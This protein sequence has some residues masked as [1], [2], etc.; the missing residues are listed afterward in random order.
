MYTFVN[1]NFIVPHVKSD[2][3]IYSLYNILLESTI[4]NNP[5]YNKK[6][7]IYDSKK[8]TLIYS[9]GHKLHS[10]NNNVYKPI[11]YEYTNIDKMKNNLFLSMNNN[12]NINDKKI[13]NIK[14]ESVEMKATPTIY[15]NEYEDKKKEILTLCKEV[16]EQYKDEQNKLLKIK[17]KMA[18]NEKNKKKLLI[19]IKEKMLSKLSKFYN[20]YKTYVSIKYMEEDSENFVV[21]S[22]FQNKYDFMDYSVKNIDLNEINNLDLDGIANDNKNIEEL[23]SN[24]LINMINEY[25]KIY[26]SL[27]VKFSHSFEEL[28]L[29]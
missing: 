20:D 4:K 11:Y 14:Y 8:N 9:D 21:P 19:K 16:E 10:L 27:N 25:D 7:Y 26:K 17:L 1:K 15:T 6:C 13:N 28:D 23:I 12:A 24:S 29:E 22:L 3:N 18:I 2:D 5:K